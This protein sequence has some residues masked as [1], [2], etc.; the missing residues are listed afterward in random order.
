M[1]IQIWLCYILI[2]CMCW[3]SCKEE[4]AKGSPGVQVEKPRAKVP[5]FD[6][7]SAYYYIEKQLSFGPRV[8]GSDAHKTC[9][10]WLIEKF[11][12]FG[13]EVIRQDFIATIYTGDN[14]ASSNIIAQYNPNLKDRVILSAHWDSR[15]I[16]EQDAD[17]SRR[18]EAIPGADDGGSGVAVLLEIARQLQS[19]PIDLGID[20]ILWD[21]EDQGQRGSQGSELSWCL[22]SQHWSQNKHKNKYQALYGINLDM[23]GGKNPRFG[24]DAVSLYYAPKV[25][26]KIWKLARIMGYSDMFVE[27]KTGA[28]M[29]DHKVVN[30]I[31]GIPMIDIINQPTDTDTH[32]V[33]YWHTHDDDI[34]NIDKRTLKTVGQIVLATIYKESDGSIASF[35]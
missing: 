12:S 20:I 33:E 24:M 10:D 26:N 9:R 29:D 15:F 6:K 7:D 4:N 5:S 21:A 11:E 35:E 25:M 2:A 14:L 1:K 27:E 16:A 30:E 18:E 32:F 8:P 22:G 3:V 17:K 28:L 34:S 13:A 31:A 23:V 19:N